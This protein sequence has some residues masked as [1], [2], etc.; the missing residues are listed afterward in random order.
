MGLSLIWG[1]TFVYEHTPLSDTTLCLW[2]RLTD[3]SCAGCGLTRSFCAMSDGQVLGAFQQHPAG[4]L[5]YFGMVVAWAQA[6]LRWRRGSPSSHALPMRLV[7]G[8]WTIL[9]VV[10]VLHMARTMLGWP[11]LTF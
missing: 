2:R 7:Q 4:P 1:L 9:A 8:Y 3:F 11:G 10:F 6:G 5:L